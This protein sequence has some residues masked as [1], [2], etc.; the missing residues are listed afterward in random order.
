[1]GGGEGGMERRGWGRESGGV[2]DL[3]VLRIRQ[4][5]NSWRLLPGRP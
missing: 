1:M 2:R 5:W 4:D 3:K